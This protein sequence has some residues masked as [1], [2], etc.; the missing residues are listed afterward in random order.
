M[1][2][3]VN[4]PEH[5]AMQ[6]PTE[7]TSTFSRHSLLLECAPIRLM[8]LSAET[9]KVEFAT[10]D[11]EQLFAPHIQNM[12][13]L[14]GLSMGQMPES[15]QEHAQALCDPARMPF[16]A[17]I[18]LG[19]DSVLMQVR[20]VNNGEGAFLGSLLALEVMTRETRMLD[21]NQELSGELAHSASEVVELSQEMS[22]S[23]DDLESV[24]SQ[25]SSA[26]TQFTA[27]VQNVAAAVEELSRSIEDISGRV[28]DSA[29]R[30]DSAAEEVRSAEQVI[31]ALADSAQDIGGVVK[32]IEDI[33]DQTNLLALNAT[34]EAA[35]AGES[36]KGFAVVASEVKALA[37]QTTEATKTITENIDRI[38][39]NA[40]NVAS[41]MNTVSESVVQTSTSATEIRAAIEQQDAATSEISENAHQASK[42]AEDLAKSIDQINLMAGQSRERAERLQGYIQ[43]VAERSEK[44]QT[45]VQDARET[46]LS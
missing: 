40:D 15:L 9:Q 36:G 11:A 29:E 6:C 46:M 1:Y 30:A 42:G 34:I 12:G 18:T 14:V 38:R 17:L 20:A 26:S 28:G 27:N 16:S 22:S 3:A 5:T 32:L 37:K 25:T 4:I 41:S 23:A 39:E 8:F 13:R 44:L 2:D 45:M 7:D 35:R 19:E 21:Y 24:G 43:G 10:S 31:K 33:A